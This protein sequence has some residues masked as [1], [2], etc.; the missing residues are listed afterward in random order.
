MAEFDFIKNVNELAIYLKTES[1]KEN[2]QNASQNAQIASTKAN[3]ASQQ[4]DLATEQAQIA[5]TKANE[6]SA[7]ATT[8]TTKANE[9]S[10]HLSNITNTVNTLTS[11][12]N[13]AQGAVTTIQD[14]IILASDVRNDIIVLKNHTEAAQEN[15]ETYS[16]LA[17][18]YKQEC[19]SAVAQAQATAQTV[20][21]TAQNLTTLSN[22]M[23]ALNESY[24]GLLNQEQSQII[25]TLDNAVEV[26]TTTKAEVLNLKSDVV[27]A[28]NVV[29][30]QYNTIGEFASSAEASALS[31]AQTKYEISIIKNNIDATLPNYT[32]AL[33]SIDAHVLM[34]QGYQQAVEANVAIVAQDKAHCI[35]IK[36]D[37]T[38]VLE[39]LSGGTAGDLLLADLPNHV[40]AG[41]DGGFVTAAGTNAINSASAKVYLDEMNGGIGISLPYKIGENTFK[42]TLVVPMYILGDTTRMKIVSND[43]S[44][45]NKV[46]SIPTMNDPIFSLSK[47]INDKLASLSYL[48]TYHMNK[49]HIYALLSTG[50]IKD[51]VTF[52]NVAAGTSYINYTAPANTYI[53][54]SINGSE[55]IANGYYDAVTH[56][57]KLNSP[58]SGTSTI[59]VKAMGIIGSAGTVTDFE[60]ALL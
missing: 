43:P 31:A 55:S 24:S 11:T 53:L 15:A 42:T 4:K 22:N 2:I 40:I 48:Q 41:I 26:V 59:R 51:D 30:S 7:S 46:M 35:Q 10:T 19:S 17:L 13:L 33:E 27:N 23:T 12:L 16:N 39:D 5:S 52:S 58:L 8:A 54:V 36:D 38:Q 29:N 25:E 3:E 6:A 50:E 56:S 45:G 57:V 9:A 44:N 28:K 14:A 47:D 49:T 18:Q 20:A 1:N 21:T 37:I 60:G 34:I 32:A